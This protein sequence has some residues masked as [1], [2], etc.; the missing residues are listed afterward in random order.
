[1][2]EDFMGEWLQAGQLLT[3]H[4]SEIR[5]VR[6]NCLHGTKHAVHCV[7]FPFDLPQFAS[8]QSV[9]HAI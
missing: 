8:A 6:L 4:A 5:T 1:M 7:L 2:L 3:S 9:N